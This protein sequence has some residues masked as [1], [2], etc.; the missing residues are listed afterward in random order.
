MKAVLEFLADQGATLVLG[1][2]VLL[3]FALALVFVH[4]Q[5]IH[6][7][8][9]AE[10]SMVLCVLF[11]ILAC[12]PLPR[13]SFE[14]KGPVAAVKTTP[15]YELQPGDEVIAAEVFKVPKASGV[16]GSTG[17]GGPLP[18]PPTQAR[19]SLTRGRAMAT[20]DWTM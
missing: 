19:G 5:P 12:V 8:R 6:R 9:I 1:T 7:Q 14:K 20:L 16:P 17:I 4:K 3:S 2:T 13:F 10:S 15:K 18:I 11:L